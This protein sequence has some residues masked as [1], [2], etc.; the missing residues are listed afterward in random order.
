MND[1]RTLD[2]VEREHI[3]LVLRQQNCN[4]S[5]AARILDIDRRTLYR[6]LDGWGI[7][8]AIAS[9]RKSVRWRWV[10]VP[11]EPEAV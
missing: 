11:V 6:K 1:T 8:D 4:M 5:E 7:R 3:E 9:E 10:R 2:Q